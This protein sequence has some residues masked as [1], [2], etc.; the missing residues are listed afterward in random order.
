MKHACH[1]RHDDRLYL[2]GHHRFCGDICQ[3]C[4][5]CEPAQLV[6]GQFFGHELGQCACNDGGGGSG[7]VGSFLLAKPIGAFQMGEDYA[8]SVGVPLKALRYL[9]VLL[10]SL[11]SA[12][13]AAFAGPVSLWALR[14]RISCVPCSRPTRPLCLSSL[15][16]RRRPVL[17]GMRYDCPHGV[18]T[19]RAEHQHGDGDLWCADRACYD[20]APKEGWAVSTQMRLSTEALAVGYGGTV[21]IRGHCAARRRRPCFNIDRTQRLR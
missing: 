8:Q 15:F 12:C 19:H 3:R 5:Y 6:Y 20:G 9:L 13:V 4:R 7:G 1:Q 14:C 16:S 21:L 2:L 18:C 11:L 17:S 10:S